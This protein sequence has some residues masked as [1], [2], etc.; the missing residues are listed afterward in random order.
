[1]IILAGALFSFLIF[2]A[3]PADAQIKIPK[4]KIKIPVKAPQVPDLDKLL[5]E[6]PPVSTTLTDAIYDIPFLDDYDPEQGAF[7]TFLPMTP[8]AGFPLLPGLWEGRFQSYCL[9]AGTYAPGEGDGYAYAPLKGKQA[10]IVSNILQNSVFHPEID[11]RDIQLLLWAIVARSKISECSKEI[12]KAAK[13]LMTPKE[14]DRLNGGALGKLPEPVLNAAMK[15]LPPL[16]REVF[17]AEARLREMLHSAVPASYHE[18][19]SVAVRVGDIL[20]PPDSREI[21]SGRWSYDPDGYFIRYFPYGYSS[22]RTQLY[23]P[24]NFIIETDDSGLITSISDR[25]GLKVQIVYDENVEPLLFAG[26]DNVAGFAFK[27][28]ILTWGGADGTANTR[29]IKDAGWVLAG[30]P[31]RGGKP[32]S[33]TVRFANASDRY[34][35]AVNHRNEVLE[36][37]DKL[38]KANPE[39]K[40]LPDSA[41]WSVIY[42]GN[43]CEAIRLT[44]SGAFGTGESNQNE[45]RAAFTGLLYRAWMKGVALLASGELGNPGEPEQDG[46]SELDLIGGAGSNLS[47]INGRVAPGQVLFEY[48]AEE[49]WAAESGCGFYTGE[50]EMTLSIQQSL[51]RRRELPK[52]VFTE[53]E[54]QKWGKQPEKPQGPQKLKRHELPWFNPNEKVAQPGNTGKQ[55]LGQSPR[56]TSSGNGR[57]AAEN[58]RKVLKWFSSGTSAGAWGAGKL[59]GPGAATPYGIPKAVAGYTIGRTVSTWGDCIDALSMDPPRN[60]Y[61]VLARPEPGSFVPIQSGAGVTRARAEAINAYLAAAIDL[62]AKM[63]AARFSVERYSGAMV[64]GDEEW[65]GRQLENA[66]KYERESGLAMLVV[67]DRLETLVKVATAEKV[68]DTPLTP[69]LIDSY[70]S[71]LQREGFSAEE[72]E[73]C[74]ALNLTPEEIEEMKARILSGE[75][76]EGPSSLYRSSREAAQALREFARLLLA[77]P[78]I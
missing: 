32:A 45:L 3:N 56:K 15:K 43:Y 51:S 71:S 62:T 33:G 46:V 20:P 49:K 69:Q 63:R 21:R 17:Q 41:A 9:K 10:D 2:P 66:I 44:I 24:E 54:K 38:A 64:A 12:Q 73:A 42:L 61:T 30:V 67:A 1:M 77:L 78:V 60:D 26:D 28:L 55:R 18:V 13:A 34:K 5:Q 72:L 22:T 76:L 40:K 14:Y 29:S 16:A 7:M 75:P 19:E 48:P 58:T 35:F 52:F 11:Q 6:E 39:L 8:Q 53:A 37:K 36:L 25:Q 47:F 68:P 31:A 57:E 23:Y 27:E 59:V 74:R 65:A 4:D 70:R 50:S